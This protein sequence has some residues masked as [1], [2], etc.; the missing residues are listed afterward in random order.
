[1][2]ATSIATL[3]TDMSQARS[4]QAVQLAA[5]KKAMDIEAQS[6]MMLVQAAAQVIPNN[7]PHLGKHVDTRA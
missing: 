1:M 7:P 6:A 2:D 5:L 3:V 4:E